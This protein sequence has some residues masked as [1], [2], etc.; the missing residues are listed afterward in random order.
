MKMAKVKLYSEI[1]VLQ[2][3][4]PIFFSI[5]FIHDIL[6]DVLWGLGISYTFLDH[7]TGQQ[8]IKQGVPLNNGAITILNKNFQF[9]RL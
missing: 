6:R 2:F 1:F 8:N 7:D 4:V 5:I 9:V 3:A